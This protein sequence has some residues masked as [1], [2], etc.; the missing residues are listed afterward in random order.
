MMRNW[1]LHKGFSLVEILVYM[2]LMSI[3]L[4]V[5]LSIFTDTLN[6]KLASES[7]SALDQD[8]RYILSRLTY[9]INN[10]DSIVAPAT[11]SSGTTL[12]IVKDG[13]SMTYSSS[14]GNFVLTSA[15]TTMN[16]NSL[17]TSLDNLNFQNVEASGAKSMVQVSYTLRSKIIVSGETATQS[18]STTIGTR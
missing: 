18:I 9:D 11:G 5:L 1:K 12:S 8:S 16:L 14:S 10:A 17:D 4:L 2:G 3:F 13:V 6:T 15:G 7:T